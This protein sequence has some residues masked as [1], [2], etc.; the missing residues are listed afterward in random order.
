MSKLVEE[1]SLIIE[2]VKSVNKLPDD[3][4][5]AEWESMV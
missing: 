2:W 1:E 3:H 4:C 5:I